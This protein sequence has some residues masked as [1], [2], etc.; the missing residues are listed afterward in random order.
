MASN[1]GFF[2]FLC[3][4]PLVTAAHTELLSTV[5]STIAPSLFSLPC[6]AQLTANSQLSTELVAP[7]RK[8]C[9]GMF[10]PICCTATIIV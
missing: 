10:T 8:H 2:S 3:S 7:N 1:S 5:N 6:R 9:L 4:G